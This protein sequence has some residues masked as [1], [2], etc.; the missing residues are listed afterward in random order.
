MPIENIKS[1]ANDIKLSTDMYK[2]AQRDKLTLSQYLEKIDPSDDYGPHEKMDALGRQLKRFGIHVA[3]SK[4]AIQNGNYADT[5]ESFY[6]TEESKVLFP[7]V[8]ARIARQAPMATSKLEQLRAITTPI[9]SNVYVPYYVDDQPAE[10]TKKRVTEAAQL[11][12]CEIKGQEHSIKLYKYGRAIKASYETIRRM[13]IDMLALHVSRIANQAALDKAD[14][15]LDV[16][17]NGDGNDN[18]ATVYELHNDLGGVVA[19]GLDYKSWLKFLMKFSAKQYNCNIVIGGMDEIVDLLTM[20]KPNV[21]PLVLVSALAQGPVK[22][23][24]QLEPDLINSYTCIYIPSAPAGKIIGI[25]NTSAIEEVTEIGSDISEAEKFIMNQTNVLTIS[26]N[27]AY[28]KM[29]KD[30]T[31]VLDLSA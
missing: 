13:K 14:E 24:M 21:D 4:D 22:A 17:I 16:I 15:A 20:S 10:Q 26:E 2:Q 1:R 31:A 12:T 3:A 19:D 9:D 8:I 23:Q 29:F 6:L 25:D 18:A 28:A 5:V 30:A 27:N 11:P 7:E